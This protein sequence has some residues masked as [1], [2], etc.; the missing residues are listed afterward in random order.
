MKPLHLALFILIL[1][2]SCGTKEELIPFTGIQTTAQVQGKDP[3]LTIVNGNFTFDEIDIDNP[4][5]KL[6]IPLLGNFVQDLAGVFADI[7]VILSDDWEVDQE[8]QYIEIPEIDEDYIVG[9]QLTKLEFRIV[10][11]SGDRRGGMF[12]R[13]SDIISNR[14]PKLDFIEKIEIYAATEQMLAED[15][16]V[17]L[18]WYYFD[19]DRL[20]KCL[21]QCIKLD[22]KQ[23]PQGGIANLVPYLTGQTKLYLFPKVQINKTPKTKIKLKGKVDFRVKVKLPF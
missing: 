17:L 9:L 1:I 19:K 6:P 14:K 10:P 2:S 15:K 16:S 18:A 13:I 7:F 23:E 3:E 21:K 11:S 22:I 4:I 8:A 20:N 12:G 5:G